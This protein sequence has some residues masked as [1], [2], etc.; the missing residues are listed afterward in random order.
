M[1]K[2]GMLLVFLAAIFCC[3][4]CIGGDGDGGNDMCWEPKVKSVAVFKN[5]LG[6]FNRQGDVSLRDGWCQSGQIPPAAFGT[7]AIYSGQKD[8]LVDIIGSGSGEIV[9]FDGVDA[10]DDV[11]TRRKRLEASVN[12]K[13]QLTYEKKGSARSAA[14]KLVSIGPKFAILESSNNSFAVPIAG[15][16]K[17]QVLELPLR[18]HVQ[19]EGKKVP[20]KTSLNMAYLRKGI[21][22][23]PEYSVEI[24]DDDTAQ[25]TLRGTLV[26]EAEDLIHC[27]VNFVVGVPHFTHTGYMAPIA[28]GQTI[29]AIGASVA[30]A[31][32]RKQIMNR[33]A[34]VSNA[35]NGDSFNQFSVINKPVANNGG[36][37]D[38][39]LG[40]LPKMGSSAGTDYTVYTKKDMTVRRG[41]KAI[42]TLFVKKI[43]YS[44]IYRWSLPA[45]VKHYLVL[46]NDT[47]T[48]WTTGP[49]LAIH[50]DNPLSEDILKYTPKGGKCEITVTQAINVSHDSSEAEIDRDLKSYSPRSSY[51][52][53]LVTLR[54]TLKIKNFEK[55]VA[56]IIVTAPVKGKAIDSSKGGTIRV[57]STKL[58]LLERAGKVT[59]KIS[60][61]PG[62]ET[63][64]TY[65]YERYISSH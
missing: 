43:K 48:A 42:V 46:Q 63:T 5:G 65:D 13:L 50:D 21:T 26:N 38:K 7:L 47:D 52:Y 25:M 44:H 37:I 9:E 33:A 57:D 30:P 60:L 14:G 39:A 64:L 19:G 51:Y 56:D 34:I 2:N 40:N 15:I 49:Y 59:W 3:G 45:R 8:H 10:A 23:I 55:R 20:T 31:Q 61:K 6:F 11:E 58:R 24:L 53:D 4:I 16:S 29:R 54:G 27:D 18:V 17:M 62:K 41:E 22:W 28:V 12:L 35:Y 1:S 36:N 32:F